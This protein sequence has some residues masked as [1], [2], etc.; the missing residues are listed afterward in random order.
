MKDLPESEKP[1]EKMEIYGPRKLTNTELLAIII[2]TGTKKE[3]ALNLAQEVLSLNTQINKENLSFLED[4]SINELMKI[5]GIGK[6]KA[7]QIIAVGELSRRINLPT[8]ASEH[9]IKNTEDIARMFMNEMS[10]EKREI[11]KLV[12]LN[13]KNIIL[14][15]VDISIGGT[16]YAIL[17]PK[18]VL[19][20]PIKM[21]APKIILIH[22]HPSGNPTPSE[23]DFQAT[24]RIYEAA[25]IMG[26][27]LLDH[28]IIGKNNQ[29]D[30]VMLQ[31]K[32][33]RKD[34]I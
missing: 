30:S 13:A 10:N 22:N 17:E 25:S 27:Q 9:K 8:N 4:L 3:S 15:I 16:S 34:Y 6:V 23:Q 28:V 18:I 14:K 5:K 1:Y 12:I 11:A 2:K 7:I 26:I 33:R 21:Q 19:S 20:E 32:S 29:F 24:D 31:K